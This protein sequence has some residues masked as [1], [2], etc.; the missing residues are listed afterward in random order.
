MRWDESGIGNN[1]STN[2]ITAISR[3]APNFK[4]TTTSH[5]I[6]FAVLYGIN[7]L[8]TGNDRVRCL[9]TG[10]LNA[11]RLYSYNNLIQ[12]YTLRAFVGDNA[13]NDDLQA[14][15]VRNCRRLWFQ[16][17]GLIFSGGRNTQ[18][19]TAFTHTHTHTHTQP[20]TSTNTCYIVAQ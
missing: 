7:I 1:G 18:S 11:S 4:T 6:I 8:Y 2:L 20:S 5:R 10:H 16:Q 14:A 9:I 17:S 15:T 19:I 12:L 3:P 13:V